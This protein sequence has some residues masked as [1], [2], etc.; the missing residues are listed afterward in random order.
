MIPR[1]KLKN[2]QKACVLKIKLILK[3]NHL[4][5]PTR[6][7]C[8]QLYG[9]VRRFSKNFSS[10]RTGI[11]FG[12]GNMYEQGKEIARGID[13]LVATPGRLIDHVKKGNI[14]LDKVTI[15]TLDEADRMLE[16]GFES[17]VRSI[18]NHVRPDRQCLFFSATFKKTIEKLARDI[19]NDPITLTQGNAGQVNEDVTQIC[20]FMGQGKY[21]KSKSECLK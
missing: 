16:L 2:H 1:V 10:L 7:L 4:K 3:L 15:I 13:I 9:E 21:F 18:C 11:V 17:Q 8:Q 14:T 5:A 12:G 6:E 20:K 19:L